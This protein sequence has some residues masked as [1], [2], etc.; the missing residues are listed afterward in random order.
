MDGGLEG[1]VAAETVLTN[2]D[3]STGT[4]LLRGH[5][6]GEVVEGH[7]YEGAIALLWEGFAGPGLT[8][9]AITAAFAEGRAIAFA[10]LPTWLPTARGRPLGEG[11]RRLLAALPD[12]STPA[13]IAAALPVGIAALL[14]A[15]RG[16][17]PIA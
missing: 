7:G 5:A 10:R 17:E 4:W 13:E 11:V 1:V 9:A 16:D 3:G 6:L 15:E 14:R 2:I 12:D 8:R